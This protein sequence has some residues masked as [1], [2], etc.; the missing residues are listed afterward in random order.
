MQF[1]KQ[2][3]EISVEK[4]K[5]VWLVSLFHSKILLTWAGNKVIDI[6]ENDKTLD[7]S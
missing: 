2:S 5:A 1:E 6:F 4:K 7:R 3:S